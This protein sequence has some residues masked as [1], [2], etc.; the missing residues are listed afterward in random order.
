MLPSLRPSLPP[1]HPYVSGDVIAD[2]FRLIR[3][4]GKGGMGV[5]WV[6]HNQILDVHVAIKVIDLR[7]VGRPKVVSARVLQEAR[8]AARLGHPAICRVFD[9]GE[10]RHG[11]P[12]VVTELLHGE[13]LAEVLKR[14]RRMPATQ[15]VT[16]LLPIAEGLALAHEKGIV[17]RDVKPENIFLSHEDVQRMRPKLLDFG[18]ARFVEADNKLTQD[19]ALLGTPHYMSPEQARGDAE[20]GARS[21]VWSLSVVLYELVTGQLPFDGENYNALLWAIGHDEPRPA[22][23]WGAGDPRLSAIL[24]RGLKKQPG[25]RWETMRAL[26]EQLAAWLHAQGVREDVCGASLRATWLEG[27][28]FDP[29]PDPT[30]ME[31]DA[32]TLPPGPPAAAPDIELILVGTP[33]PGTGVFAR[34]LPP[35]ARPSEARRRWLLAAGAVLLLGLAITLLLSTRSRVVA[36]A[37][38]ASGEVEPEHPG[39]PVRTDLSLPM[40]MASEVSSGALPSAESSADPASKRAPPAARSRPSRKIVSERYDLGF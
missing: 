16:W 22:V 10:T 27:T 40:M 5:V 39:L 38:V 19:G 26:G 31:V 32:N 24:A 35:V 14:Q 12:F 37:P 25:E 36:T 18:I 21:D 1:D 13:T 29:G 9:F 28:A 8:T 2:K 11:D 17:H 20:L 23:D 7:H 6:A 34:P 3:P 30:L 15:A 33:E 4:L